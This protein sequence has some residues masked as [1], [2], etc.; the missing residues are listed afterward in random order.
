MQY[1]IF[2][3]LRCD[4]GEQQSVCS[5][6]GVEA[7]ALQ[8]TFLLNNN[9]YQFESA[10]EWEKQVFISNIKTF[11]KVFGYNSELLEGTQYNQTLLETLSTIKKKCEDDK[12]TFIPIKIE[13]LAERSV[14]DN[15][16]EQAT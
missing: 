15:I 12:F 7:S 9:E 6:C 10:N 5:L 11:N 16:E 4:N 13:Y 14:P 2:G 3:K 8:A 1:T